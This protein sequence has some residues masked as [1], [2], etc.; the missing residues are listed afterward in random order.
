MD[1]GA[2]WAWSL[3]ESDHSLVT[4]P[5]K[6]TGGDLIYFCPLGLSEQYFYRYQHGFVGEICFETWLAEMLLVALSQILLARV[7]LEEM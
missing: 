7:R 3:K 6:S 4:K 1:R 2:C 5:A